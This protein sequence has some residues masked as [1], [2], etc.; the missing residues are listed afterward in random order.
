MQRNFTFA[1]PFGTSNI[2]TTYDQ[3]S[4]WVSVD[5]GEQ[6]CFTFVAELRHLGDNDWDREY[7]DLYLTEAEVAACQGMNIFEIADY[8]QINRDRLPETW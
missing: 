3:L 1:T 2:S 8:L 7:S 6:G 5:A 4:V